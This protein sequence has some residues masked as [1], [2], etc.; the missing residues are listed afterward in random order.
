MTD[1]TTSRA[2]WRLQVWL[3]AWAVSPVFFNA[4]FYSVV[5]RGTAPGGNCDWSKRLVRASAASVLASRVYK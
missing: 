5:I 1:H 4:Y 3:H 2:I